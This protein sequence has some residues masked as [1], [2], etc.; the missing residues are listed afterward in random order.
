MEA[1]SRDDTTLRRWQWNLRP[2]DKVAPY[3]QGS[4][5]PRTP[6]PPSLTHTYKRRL[7]VGSACLFN[8][9][10]QNR[11][12]KFIFIQPRVKPSQKSITIPNKP[13]PQILIHLQYEASVDDK[14]IIKD[15]RIKVFGYCSRNITG[16][17]KQTTY[18]KLTTEVSVHSWASL[19][20]RGILGRFSLSNKVPATDR[21]CARRGNHPRP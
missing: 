16:F 2:M 17:E 21:S 6:P 14:L 18:V 15:V 12:M 9:I 4:I 20:C 13:S 3:C 7:S 19:K 8:N 1:S 10:V 5:P 11:S